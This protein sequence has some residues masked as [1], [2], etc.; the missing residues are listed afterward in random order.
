MATCMATSA[1]VLAKLHEVQHGSKVNKLVILFN[2]HMQP[3]AHLEQ[4]SSAPLY[5]LTQVG[6]GRLQLLQLSRLL[7]KACKATRLSRGGQLQAARA[8][9]VCHDVL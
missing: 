1:S 9:H 5:E 7:L 6:V 3:F 4:G 8:R 2:R